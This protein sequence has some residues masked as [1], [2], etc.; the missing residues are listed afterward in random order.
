[1][2]SCP[3]R[4]GSRNTPQSASLWFVRTRYSA[5]L[6]RVAKT[7]AGFLARSRSLVNHN[8]SHQDLVRSRA[9]HTGH[10]SLAQEGESLFGARRASLLSLD[11]QRTEK[12]RPYLQRWIAAQ[13][14]TNDPITNYEDS[15][16]DARNP[17]LMFR[18]DVA[19]QQ[20]LTPFF[21]QL[22]PYDA[23][24]HDDPSPFLRPGDMILLKHQNGVS[25][26]QLAIYLRT[27]NEQL[28]VYSIRGKW[29]IAR[30]DEV[31]FITGERIPAESLTPI[32]PYVPTFTISQNHTH[33]VEHEGGIP[34]EIGA[35]LLTTMS[36]F[37]QATLELFTQHASALNSIYEEFAREKASVIVT[38]DEIA[39]K[40]LGRDRQSLTT[41]H[42]FTVYAALDR[43]KAGVIPNQ[44]LSIIESYTFR[45]K[46][47]MKRINRVLDWM[48]EYQS[49]VAENVT[50]RTE[51][52]LQYHPI[53]NFL[54]K[55][56]RLITLSRKVRTPA[57]S[58]IS[59]RTNPDTANDQQL[60]V[61]LNAIEPFSSSDKVIIDFLR[62]WVFPPLFY[63]ATSFRSAGSLILNNIGLYHGYPLNEATAYLALQELGV[64][65]PWENI[66]VLN[67]QLALPGHGVSLES[68]KMVAECKAFCEN[69]KPDTFIDSMKH[70]RRD[71]GNLPVFCV[72]SPAAA[73]IDDGFSIE[74]IPESPDTFWVHIH[75]A[76]PSAFI[77]HD[78]LL[79]KTAARFKRSFYSPERIYSMFPP[80]L[81]HELFSLGPNKPTITFSAKVN[82]AGDI[83][84][85]KVTHG[86]INNVI[87]ITPD[88]LR[89]MF[90]VDTSDAPSLKLMVG[91][92]IEGP[93]R[94][95]LQDFISDEHQQLLKTLEKVLAGRQEQRN[96]KGAI[97]YISHTSSFPLVSGPGESIQSDAGSVSQAHY[98]E[99]DPVI[100]ISGNLVDPYKIP[101]F[102]K[103]DL[104]SH[105][106]LLGGEIAAQWCK[107]RGIPV[108]FSGTAIRP[109]Q[110]VTE[111]QLGGFN[112]KHP[113]SLLPRAFSSSSPIR[114]I[115][116]GMDQY[117][118][119]TSPLRRY[120]DLIAHWQI[121]A[122]LRHEAE[123]TK[124]LSPEDDKSILPFSKDDVTA[125]INR[126][127]WQNKVADLAQT[128]SRDFWILQL[129][130]RSFY[131]NQAVLPPTF[132]CII[133]H[134]LTET[135]SPNL[136]PGDKQY[137]ANLLPF[138]VRC[139]ITA[140]NGTPEFRA[141]DLVESK[142]SD[143]NLYSLFLNM[144]AIRLVQRP[145]E[146][147]A[148]AAL[149]FLLN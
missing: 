124:I 128:R 109:G 95:E 97:Q 20:N 114:H 78:H 65:A 1:M 137:L 8:G 7:P 92:T 57:S 62:L 53:T 40:V 44:S 39:M 99:Y 118:K 134:Q 66:H 85:T 108:I 49:N 119:V 67:E 47:Q 82:F 149:G 11:L 64:L 30:P 145:N 101:D 76:N 17:G 113:F 74:S 4:R 60:D 72:D 90:G 32:L 13:P 2:F 28:Q 18:D 123:T 143:I 125:I 106:M 84:D 120:S 55:A 43:Y 130:H 100:G 139:V 148:T 127:N 105:A 81:T 103:Q 147:Q 6:N 98:P 59:P 26:G 45:P 50:S 71:W 87:Y 136:K 24:S 5:V 34:R 33:L 126:S 48:R 88:R 12:I 131:F 37:E 77:P 21:D 146:K 73:E 46:E 25:L 112:E 70:L 22:T 69:V 68:D 29:R 104:V 135:V 132:Q 10:A 91:G 83:L 14:T 93:A 3:L 16:I 15:N 111:N 129:L 42:R 140:T 94:S 61:N 102:T 121:E 142:I 133:A 107:D 56:R 31:V 63:R 51:K 115:A 19:Y 41:V 141:G 96:K 36:K 116:L 89:K 54:K 86:T 23:A 117:S 9:F 35:H 75:V 79:A 138:G 27:V 110:L 38:L 58:G 80:E 122:S 144:D 52:N